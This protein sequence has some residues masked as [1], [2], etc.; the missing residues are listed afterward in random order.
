M[1]EPLKRL[2]DAY[3]ATV[4]ITPNGNPIP[5]AA[6]FPGVRQA[7][8]D[9]DKMALRVIR[10]ILQ[11]AGLKWHGWHAFRRGLA[12]LN[13]LGV[14]LLTIQAILRHGDPRVTEKAYVKRLPKQS[15][16]AMAKVAAALAGI[17]SDDTGANADVESAAIDICTDGF[18]QFVVKPMRCPT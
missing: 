7:Y 1:I 18:S 6:I 15:V 4:P 3:K 9:L 12:T 13:D 8:A 11:T 16:E 2:L 17:V 14:P 5:D 10:P